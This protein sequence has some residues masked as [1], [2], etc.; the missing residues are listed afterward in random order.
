MEVSLKRFPQSGRLSELQIGMTEEHIVTLCGEPEMVGGVSSNYGQHSI[1]KY[2]NLEIHFSYF[3]PRICAALFID[4]ETCDDHVQ[5]PAPFVIED[6]HLTRNS[7][8][9]EVE[10]YLQRNEIEY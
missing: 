6:W 4:Y 2:G 3:P 1:F 10:R 9:N 8:R 7:D 5:L